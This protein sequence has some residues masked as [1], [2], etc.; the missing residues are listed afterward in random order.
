MIKRLK[1]A[2]VVIVVPEHGSPENVLLGV[3]FYVEHK[4]M[5]NACPWGWFC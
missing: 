3:E 5:Q 1:G 4:G 2:R